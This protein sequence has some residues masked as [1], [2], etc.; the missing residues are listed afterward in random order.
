MTRSE[1]HHVAMTQ[2]P[3]LSTQVAEEI[4]ALLARRRIS[5]RQLAEATGMSQSA[6]SARLTGTTA[7]DLDDLQRI[8]AALGVEPFD[9]FPAELVTAPAASVKPRVVTRGGQPGRR[10]TA[11]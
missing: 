11:S 10:L 8:A 4:R 1:G 3:T 5:G 7:I 2:N 6:I 9:L